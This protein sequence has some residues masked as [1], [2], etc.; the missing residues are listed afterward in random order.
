MDWTGGCL[1]GAVRYRVE[2]DPLWFC[3]CHCSMCR[4]QTGAAFGTYV[5]F[6]ATAFQW[7]AGEATLYRSSGA[8]DRG[9]CARC[10]STLTFHRARETS[11]ALGSLDRPEKIEVG[12]PRPEY[13]DCHIWIEDQLPW[14]NIDDCLDRFPRFPSGRSKDSPGG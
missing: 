2:G 3:H 5:G 13:Q 11:L 7:T 12:A 1:C 4:K 9:F 10:G 6:L 8:V 14:L